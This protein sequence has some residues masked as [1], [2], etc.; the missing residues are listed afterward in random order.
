MKIQHPMLVRAVGVTGAWMIRRLVGTSRFYFRYADPRVNPE[1]AR[2][3]GQRYIYAFFHEVMLF[4][5]FYWAWPEMQILI[6][7]HRDG[8]CITQVVKRLGFGVVR[9][10]TTRGGV[11]LREMAHRIDSG[12]LCVTPT[13]PRDR[14]GTSTRDLPTWAQSWHDAIR[15]IE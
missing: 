13:V 8:E 5:A 3:T 15:L 2:R 7:D 11:G 1:V 10:S 4:P 9:G 14:V 12:N 6:S